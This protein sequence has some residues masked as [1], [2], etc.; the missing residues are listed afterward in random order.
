ME[1]V[2]EQIIAILSDIRGDVEDWEANKELVHSGVLDSLGIVTLIGELK[3]RLRKSFMRTS[4]R[5]MAL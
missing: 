1:N 5:S 3:S 2:K 4:I